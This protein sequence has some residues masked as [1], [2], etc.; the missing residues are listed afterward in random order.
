M[1]AKTPPNNKSGLNFE[2][3]VFMN[4]IVGHPSF[5]L[6]FH[7]THHDCMNLR[8]IITQALLALMIFTFAEEASLAMAI[9]KEAILKSPLHK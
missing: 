8:Q 5:N 1:Q 6:Y 4:P 2:K 3:N 9:D 7:I